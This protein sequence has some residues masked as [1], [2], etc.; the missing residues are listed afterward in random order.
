MNKKESLA[1]YMKVE[2]EQ[3]EE[4]PMSDVEFIK[5]HPIT[6]SDDTCDVFTVPEFFRWLDLVEK[7]VYG[8]D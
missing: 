7:G 2:I 1:T 6:G 8:N 3:A 5:Q 4:T